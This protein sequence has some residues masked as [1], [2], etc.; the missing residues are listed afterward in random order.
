MSLVSPFVGVL[1]FVSEAFL[2]RRRRSSRTEGSQNLDAGSLA[3]LW[4]VITGAIVAAVALTSWRIGSR[5][6]GGL[7]WGVLGAGVWAAGAAL[8][9]WAIWHLGRF[10]TVDVAVSA[11]QRVVDDGPYRLVRH[12]SYT[13]LWLEAIGLGLALGNLLGLLTL[14]IPVLLALLHRIRIEEQALRT[15]LGEPYVR[16]CQRTRR[17]LPFIY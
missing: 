15:A 12:P 3:L 17:L 1:F 7:P 2:A 10:F 6:P 9:W 13:G 8:R 4:R 5:L 16:Y 14:A 11:E